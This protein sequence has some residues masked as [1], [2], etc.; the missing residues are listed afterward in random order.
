MKGRNM[1]NESQFWEPLKR[2]QERL[3]RRSM[4]L[5]NRIAE[6]KEENSLP[7]DEEVDLNSDSTWCT[8]SRFAITRS[9]EIS[10]Y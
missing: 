10:A 3:N 4:S 1:T 7:R 9:Q 5:A 6:I 8:D 2:A